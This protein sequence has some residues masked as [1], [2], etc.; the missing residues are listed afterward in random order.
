MFWALI[1][2]LTVVSILILWLQFD[3]LSPTTDMLT[4]DEAEKLIHERYQG[5]V[6]Q[7]KIDS[8]QYQIEMKKQNKLY[9][10]K[11]DAVSG[12]V[13]SFTLT[14]P[15]TETPPEKPVKELS[16]DEIRTIIQ[17]EVKGS[18]T[19]IERINNNQ[20]PIY[21]AVVN[22]ADKQ[23]TITVDAISGKILSTQ[24]DVI[25]EAPK[26]LTEQEAGKIALEQ[27]PGTI[28]DILLETKNEQTY[29]LVEIETQDDREAIVQIHAITGKVL[30][31]TLDDHDDGD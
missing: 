26:T 11:M 30:S 5:T 24:S 17:N 27:I 23:T 13:L 29:Y 18:I 12:K 28:D 2:S 21:K 9:L 15:T 19:S 31:I 25:K 20:E 14:S 1:G 10:I 8:Q 22:E 3:K 7:I 6:T 4:K 16:E